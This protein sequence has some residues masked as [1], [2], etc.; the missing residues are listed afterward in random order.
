MKKKRYREKSVGGKKI[1]Y[2]NQNLQEHTCVAT[3]ENL[4]CIWPEKEDLS[5]LKAYIE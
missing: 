4:E 5:F 1:Y 3:K 2:R